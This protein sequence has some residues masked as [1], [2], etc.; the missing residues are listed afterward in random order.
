MLEAL[1]EWQSKE[2]IRHV[3]EMYIKSFKAWTRLEVRSF[4]SEELRLVDQLSEFE[5]RR[6]F[7]LR[8]LNMI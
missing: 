4:R 1:P 7:L 8:L 2:S 6:C 3:R 5:L